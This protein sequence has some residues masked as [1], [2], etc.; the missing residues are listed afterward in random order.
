[1]A[2]GQAPKSFFQSPNFSPIW[3]NLKELATLAQDGGA[4]AVRPNGRRAGSGG[5][6]RIPPSQWRQDNQEMFKR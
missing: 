5:L 6:D 2:I 1:M 3:L 4:P